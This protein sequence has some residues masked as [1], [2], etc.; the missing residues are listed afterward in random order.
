MTSSGSMKR[1]W[2]GGAGVRERRGAG[3]RRERPRSW[4]LTHSGEPGMGAGGEGLAPDTG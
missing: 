2:V 4:G 3:R 1:R